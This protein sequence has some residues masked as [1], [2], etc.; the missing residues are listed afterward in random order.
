MKKTLLMIVGVLI[1][2][3]IN[4]NAVVNDEVDT[5]SSSEDEFSI[6]ADTQSGTKGE[7]N[8][9]NDITVS[10]PIIGSGLYFGESIT[11]DSTINGVAILAGTTIDINGNLEYGAL[12]GTN[13]T[14]SGKI[15]NDV[16]ISG[17]SVTL[18]NGQLARDAFI[19]SKDLF[20]SGNIG[21]D[22]SYVGQKI[23]IKSGSVISGNIWIDAQEIIIEDNVTINGKIEHRLNANLNIANSDKYIIRTFSANRYF[24]GQRFFSISTSFVNT[25]LSQIVVF[26]VGM[27][28]FPKL[29]KKISKFY[30]N[31][32]EVGSG[33]LTGL[34]TTIILPVAAIF[35]VVL[36]FTRGLS[37]VSIAAFIIMVYLSMIVV[38]VMVGELI[39]KLIKKDMNPYVSGA[40][41][42]FVVKL[43][44]II[45]GLFIIPILLGIGSIVKLLAPY[46]K[47]KK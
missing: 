16:F 47:V 9:K 1:T 44:C 41:G 12:F 35:L 4:V 22:L 33:L 20:I 37:F 10:N 5:T 13:I 18:S 30:K 46:A 17:E 6:L 23:I 32:K 24:V 38:G 28:F 43:V 40:I 39:Q 3:T 36:P 31:R 11:I 42:I 26:L 14:I 21:R 45:P 34:V 25:T 8:I 29:F 7:I 19:A 2:L 15:L 27:L